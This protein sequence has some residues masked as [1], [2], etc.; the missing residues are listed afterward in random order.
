MTDGAGRKTEHLK[1]ST[2]PGAA[3]PSQALQQL[4]DAFEADYELLRLRLT[5]YLK[6]SEAAAE[7]LHDT[8]IKLRNGPSIGDL[9]YPRAYLFRMAVN[10]AKNRQRKEM[11]QLSDDDRL[12]DQ[13]P[14]HSP[15]PERA[16][17]A[18]LEMERTLTAL[19]ALSAQRRAI[20]LARW[21]DDRSHAEIAKEFHLHKRTVQKEL[22]RAEQYLRSSLVRST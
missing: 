12:I 1:N 7:A 22:A 19:H 18:S 15:D 17:L 6:S 11:R 3:A 21:R 4:L 9:R 13:I 20:F 16:V 8:Y 2:G 5:T 10:L 14:D